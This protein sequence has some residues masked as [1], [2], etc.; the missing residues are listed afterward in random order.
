MK[1]E[2]K[3]AL[4]EMLESMETEQLDTM[5]LE[6]LKN[7]MPNEGHIRMIGSVLEER[8]QDSIAEIDADIQ[9]AWDRYQRKNTSK[10]NQSKRRSRVLVKA[11]SWILVLF[12]LLAVLPQKAEAT[13]FFRRFIDWT[14]DMFAFITPSDKTIP[15]EEYVFQTNNPGL[16][17]VYDK[18]TE[19][20]ITVPVVPTWLPAGYTLLKCNLV[21]NPTKR[22]LTGSFSNGNSLMVYQLTI[23]ADNITSTYYKDGEII[24]EKEIHGITHT[25]LRNT[26]LLVAAWVVD[27]IEC[28]I[29]IDCPED[30]LIQILESIYTM[31]EMK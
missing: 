8:S 12:T 26:D 29:S 17:M 23:Y 1:F 20:G 16:Q 28:S 11:A 24:R 3:T 25:L 30:I 14:E 9:Q 13:N 31:E 10:Y 19:L 2:N 6:E 18:V 15:S 21:E 4:R 22:L 7:E 27:N 5:L